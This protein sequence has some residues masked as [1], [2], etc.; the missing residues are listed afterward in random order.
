MGLSEL[1]EGRQGR[2]KRGSRTDLMH[3]DADG[4]REGAGNQKKNMGGEEE[5]KLRR[6]E[7]EIAER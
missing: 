2:G 7:E 4:D 1:S 5:I 3:E 6:G